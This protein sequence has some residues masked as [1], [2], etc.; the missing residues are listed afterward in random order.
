MT[1]DFQDRIDS[2]VKIIVGAAYEVSNNLGS[3]FMEKVYERSLA[4][5][6]AERGLSVETQVQVPARYKGVEVG[7]YVADMIVERQLLVELKCTE[8]LTVVHLAQCIN[9]LKATG[10]SI[11]LLFNFRKPKV[12]CK[13][14]VHNF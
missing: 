4:F 11:C 3:G 6:L 10:M 7:C 13:R 8:A 12:E 5:E 1:F 9:Y 2:L 14:M